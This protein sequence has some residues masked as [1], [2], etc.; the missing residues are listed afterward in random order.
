MKINSSQKIFQKD[1]KVRRLKMNK[2]LALLEVELQ[3][4]VIA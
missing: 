3:I 4:K 1:Q 2:V